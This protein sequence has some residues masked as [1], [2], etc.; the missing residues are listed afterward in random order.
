MKAC[1]QRRLCRSSFDSLADLI[2][3]FHEILR[4]PKY[5]KALSQPSVQNV[6]PLGKHSNAA[7]TVAVHA[8][9]TVG[10]GAT[11]GSVHCRGG[12]TTCGIFGCS[13]RLHYAQ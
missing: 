1:I 13:H 6:F 5:L 7:A 8:V 12:S 11:T 3:S 2:T 4:K 9:A 10:D